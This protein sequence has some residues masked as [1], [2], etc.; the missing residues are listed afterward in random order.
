[1]NSPWGADGTPAGGA[2]AEGLNKMLVIAEIRKTIT[3][4]RDLPTLPGIVVEVMKRVADP[5]S[6]AGDIVELIEEDVSLAGKLLRTANS[7]YYGVPRK[8]DNLKTAVVIIGIEEVSNLIASASVLR[9]F[10]ERPDV[11][12]FDSA[13]FWQHS[14][15]VAEI[16]QGLY[17]GLRVPKHSGAYVAGLL[18][19]IGKLVLHQYFYR[20][21]LLCAEK[22]N[23]EGVHIARAEADVIGVDHGHIGGWLAG[24]WNLPDDIIN[25]I[26]QHHIR[27]S[28]SPRLGLPEMLDW[29]DR[30]GHLMAA[31]TNGRVTKMLMADEAFAEIVN[32]RSV[33]L[34]KVIED[35]RERL[36]RSLQLREILG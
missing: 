25:A 26:A 36:E 16:V 8:I 9:L 1:M 29:A 34:L 31:H 11:A 14:A 13:E 3:E 28:D 33:N 23:Q 6:S 2:P 27:P 30:I 4:V 21:H 19:D 5:H 12:H 22:A 24:R 15:S 32:A 10:P 18:H 17:A 7:A 20:Y 35:L